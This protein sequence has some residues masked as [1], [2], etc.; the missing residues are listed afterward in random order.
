MFWTSITAVK[1]GAAMNA[2]KSAVD[3]EKILDDYRAAYIAVHNR[4]PEIVTNAQWVRLDGN[5][6]RITDIAAM[7]QALRKRQTTPEAKI[8]PEPHVFL[9]STA[10]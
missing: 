1:T 8:T 4:E 10:K 5:D 6:Y 7:T 3:A 9:P 2:A